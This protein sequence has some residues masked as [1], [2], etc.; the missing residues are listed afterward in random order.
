[1]QFDWREADDLL[2]S[3]LALVAVMR[4]LLIVSMR[5]SS[6]GA[7]VEV[8]VFGLGSAA[9]TPCLG[10]AAERESAWRGSSPRAT[11][12]EMSDRH[13][14]P[15]YSFRQAMATTAAAALA[16]SPTA[17]KANCAF[18]YRVS[19]SYPNE[20]T[21]EV[22]LNAVFWA[23]PDD[24][25][26]SFRLD[27][28]ELQPLDGGDEGKFQFVPP[29]PLSP[30]MHDIEISTRT[31]DNQTLEDQTLRFRVNAVEQA[32]VEADATIESVSYYP[33]VDADVRYPP[34]EP[35]EERC[36]ALA[37]LIPGLCNDIIPASLTR[38]EFSTHG[39]PIG[40]LLGSDILPPA[41]TTYFPY[42]FLPG[43]R[44]PYSIRAILPTGLSAARVFEVD[45]GVLG[46][47][48]SAA[49]EAA[50]E[51]PSLNQPVRAPVQ[52]PRG[53]DSCALHSPATGASQ[54]LLW[55]A[56]AAALASRLRRRRARRA[57][58]RRRYSLHRILLEKW[59]QGITLT[60]FD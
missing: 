44:A 2:P 43:Q 15:R 32:T 10:C 35:N 22:P 9:G 38:I 45:G 31:F 4:E 57:C 7:L 11:S 14:A 12:E 16:L 25:A 13:A 20:A 29:Q 37:T 56:A 3:V 48:P 49:P 50:A 21:R 36:A 41:C 17:A 30:G 18:E 42:E 1:M 58:R 28:V 59:A 27:G 6:P 33:V 39:N 46:S 54:S 23:V 53:A 26:V 40:Y 24:G 5:S 34:L 47:A 51:Q 55:L 60:R 8:D 19:F 52:A